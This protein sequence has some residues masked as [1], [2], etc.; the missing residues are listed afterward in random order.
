VAV[1]VDWIE[2]TEVPN[3][4]VVPNAEGVVEPTTAPL[5]CAKGAEAILCLGVRV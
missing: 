1:D 4:V 3:G 5:S 2:T